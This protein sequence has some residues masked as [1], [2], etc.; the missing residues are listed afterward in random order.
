MKIIKEDGTEIKE[1]YQWDGGLYLDTKGIAT[2]GYAHFINRMID[3]EVLSTAIVDGKAPIPNQLLVEGGRLV[4]YVYVVSS[5]YEKTLYEKQFTIISRPKPPEYIEIVTP[6]ITYNLFKG[7]RA[8]QVLKKK[9]DEDFDWEWE[10]EEGGSGDYPDLT[11]KPRINDIE[12]N[13]NK[14]LNDLGILNSTNERVNTI[15]DTDEFPLYQNGN[16][17]TLFSSIRYAIHR[18][19][20][21]GSKDIGPD[22]DNFM[23]L[24]RVRFRLFD[25]VTRSRFNFNR[26]NVAMT[27]YSSL[28]E[29]GHEELWSA[30]MVDGHFLLRYTNELHEE[31]SEE[32]TVDINDAKNIKTIPSLTPIYYP[33]IVAQPSWWT[34]LANPVGAYTHHAQITLEFID[35]TKLIEIGTVDDG[36]DGVAVYA[37]RIIGATITSDNKVKID[38]AVSGLPVSNVNIS[39][40]GRE[41]GGGQ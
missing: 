9:S 31:M 20:G 39:L 41:I 10:D 7:G 16:K 34:P 3:D 2:D 37:P 12:L 32:Y 26:N 4:C 29:E 8:G 35:A 1:L 28:D 19:M 40:C 27:K 18:W 33:I 36:S 30:M 24:T 11:N 21:I 5:D 17:K 22:Y 38:V 23:F 6:V 14:S 13:G 15:N 25:D